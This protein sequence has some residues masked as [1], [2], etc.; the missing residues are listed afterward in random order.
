MY[1]PKTF[2]VTDSS[3]LHEFIETYS[4]GTLVTVAGEQPIAT[5]LPLILD[6]HAANRVR[7]SATL[8]GPTRNGV[9]LTLI[10]NAW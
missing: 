7:C 5:R 4:F 10:G 3:T 2:E 9:P 8:L 1:I 6:R